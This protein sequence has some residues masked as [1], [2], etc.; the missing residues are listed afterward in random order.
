MRKAFPFF[1]MTLSLVFF[2]CGEKEHPP[3]SHKQR[4][5]ATG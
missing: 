2:G 5:P 4:P 1:L 3:S